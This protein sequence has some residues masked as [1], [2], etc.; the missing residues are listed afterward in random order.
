MHTRNAVVTDVGR[1]H[2]FPVRQVIG[3]AEFQ[4]RLIN[5]DLLVKV[6]SVDVHFVY[7]PLPVLVERGEEEAVGIPVELYVRNGNIGFGLVYPAAFDLSAQAREQV[8]LGIVAFT[9]VGK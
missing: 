2:Y 4:I 1:R 8:D 9:R 5:G 6:A 3:V 7:L